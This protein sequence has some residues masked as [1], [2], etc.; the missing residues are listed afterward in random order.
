MVTKASTTRV[1]HQIKSPELRIISEEGEQLG[2]MSLSEALQAAHEQELD[3]VEVSPHANPP[4]AK[5]IDFAK[6][7]Y[8]LQKAEALQRKNAKKVEV[9]TIRLSVR[10]GDHDLITKAKR[11]DEF[12]E[13]GNLIKVE[14]RMRGREQ[15]FLDVAEEQIVKFKSKLTTEVREEVPLKKMGNTLAV[16]YA[17]TK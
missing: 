10:I 12:L 14:L 8:Q 17:P 15:A 2:V 1:N 5:I 13:D 9:K 6:Y 7:R 11:A 3:L 16:T 4:V